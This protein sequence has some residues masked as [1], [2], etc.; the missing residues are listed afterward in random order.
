MHFRHGEPSDQVVLPLGFSELDDALPD[1]GLPRGAVIEVVVQGGAALAT[2]TAL[3]A[4]KS[5]QREAVARGGEAPFCAFIDP[6]A[7]LHGPGVAAAGVDLE[8]L[9]VVRP[10]LEALSRTA[11]RVVESQ[12]FSVVVVDAAGI[13]GASLDVALGGWPRVVRRLALA[14]EESATTVLLVTDAEARRPLPLPVAMRVELARAEVDR[15]T[16]R[17]AKERRGRISGPR[18][19]V[20]TRP[21]AKPLKQRHRAS[22]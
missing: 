21:R 9:L 13:P 22:A 6:T 4:C 8:R 16:V 14:A 11:I 10:S 17:I 1:G 5:A 19:I 15:L 3:M 2:S 18:S 20:W 12:A 7:T